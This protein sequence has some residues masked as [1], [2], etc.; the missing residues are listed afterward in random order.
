MSP[1][2]KIY[3][4][5]LSRWYTSKW[6]RKCFP[7]IDLFNRFIPHLW[8]TVCTVTSIHLFLQLLLYFVA[9]K[10]QQCHCRDCD[11][12]EPKK[13]STATVQENSSR[14]S[15][16]LPDHRQLWQHCGLSTESHVRK[17]NFPFAQVVFSYSYPFSTKSVAGLVRGQCLVW[18]R[19]FCF[20]WQKTGSGPV[21]K[22]KNSSRVA[23]ALCWARGKNCLRQQGGGVVKTN[24]NSKTARGRHFQ[25][26]NEIIWIAVTCLPSD[27]VHR[28]SPGETG[29]CYADQARVWP[30]TERDGCGGVRT[31]SR[32]DQQQIK[33]T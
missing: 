33:E 19:V 29:G 16:C 15:P 17:K 18:N 2:K 26:S 21:K 31:Y 23:P 20:H 9:S 32:A 27:M 28:W 12:G 10:V 5:I 13:P 3:F 25:I 22:K 6:N 4:V 11:K 14:P 30:T 24:N 8:W 7:Q 1:L